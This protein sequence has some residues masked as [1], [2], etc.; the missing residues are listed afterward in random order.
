M[1]RNEVD[2][3]KSYLKDNL[4]KLHQKSVKN[5]TKHP[6]NKEFNDG[7]SEGLRQAGGLVLN[8]LYQMA[9]AGEE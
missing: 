3:V 7:Y 6:Q 5:T 1:N 4:T 8:F 9:R 2:I